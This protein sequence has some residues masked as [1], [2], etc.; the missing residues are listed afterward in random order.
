MPETGFGYIEVSNN[1]SNDY[2]NIKSFTEKPNEKTAKK[3]IDLGNYLWNSGMFMFKAS[4]YLNELKKFEPEIFTCC[5]N[6]FETEYI[7]NDFR[8]NLSNYKYS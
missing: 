8:K 4:V 2:F 6:S 1:P 7:D 3:Y 5:K